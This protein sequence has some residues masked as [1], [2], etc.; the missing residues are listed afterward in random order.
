MDDILAGM[1]SV[2]WQGDMQYNGIIVAAKVCSLAKVG[3]TLQT[4]VITL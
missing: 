1:F 2:V 3:L 4:L